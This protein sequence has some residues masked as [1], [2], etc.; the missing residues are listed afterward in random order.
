MFAYYPKML[1]KY[2]SRQHKVLNKIFE[3]KGIDVNEAIAIERDG[4]DYKFVKKDSLNKQYL[5]PSQIDKLIKAGNVKKE[6]FNLFN[7]KT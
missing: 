7:T 3:I 1:K 4:K 6:I 5:E 2:I